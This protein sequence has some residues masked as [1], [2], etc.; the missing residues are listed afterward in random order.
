MYSAY[1][2]AP[3]DLVAVLYLGRLLAPAGVTMKPIARRAGFLLASILFAWQLS[4]SAS[5]IFQRKNVIHA[6]TEL[7]KVVR[8]RYDGTKTQRL[9]FPLAQPYEIMEFG[10][11][12]DYTGLPVRQVTGRPDGQPDIVLVS[13]RVSSDGRCLWYCDIMC[14]SGPAPLAGDLLIVLPDDT[15]SLADASIYRNSGKLLFS[16]EP[17]PRRPSWLYGFCRNLQGVFAI[18][19]SDR[20]LYASVILWPDS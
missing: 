4:L 5:Y 12:L 8:E 20:W 7:A 13:S 2:L 9:F 19:P 11:Y 10:S 6:K 16:Y 15:G 17:S 1:Y 14:L 18:T 3:V